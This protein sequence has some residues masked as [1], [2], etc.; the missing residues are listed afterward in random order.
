MIIIMRD[1]DTKFGD[2]YGIITTPSL[3]NTKAI[4][5]IIDD[6]ET[7]I[8][9]YTTEDIMDRLPYGCTFYEAEEVW[10]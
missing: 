8:E 6:V 3:V 9:G 7:N 2:I 5:D 4:Q 1:K 10:F